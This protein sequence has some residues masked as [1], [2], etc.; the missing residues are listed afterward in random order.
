MSEDEVK[1]T[2]LVQ[3]LL[4]HEPRTVDSHEAKMLALTIAFVE[5][6]SAC[7]DRSLAIGHLTGSAWIVDPSR[8]RTLLTHACAACCTMRAD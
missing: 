4:S 8:K 2:A 5:A 1:R 6:E 3:L 7:A